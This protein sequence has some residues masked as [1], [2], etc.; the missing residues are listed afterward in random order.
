MRGEKEREFHTAAGMGMS[1]LGRLPRDGEV[2]MWHG[3]RFEVLELRGARI[4]RLA[5]IP[6]SEQSPADDAQ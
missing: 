2:F 5:V 6:P 1:A 3:F 4:E